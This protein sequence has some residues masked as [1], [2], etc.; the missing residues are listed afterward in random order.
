MPARFLTSLGGVDLDKSRNYLSYHMETYRGIYWKTK[1]RMASHFLFTLSFWCRLGFTASLFCILAG[2]KDGVSRGIDVDPEAKVAE[3]PVPVVSPIASGIPTAAD[4]VAQVVVRSPMIDAKKAEYK[5]CLYS[6]ELAILSPLSGEKVARHLL[7]FFPGFLDREMQPE[8]H[9]KLGEVLRVR[10]QHYD[11]MP[12]VVRDLARID[13]VDDFELSRWFAVA[14]VKLKVP[15]TAFAEPPRGAFLEE[16]SVAESHKPVVWPRSPAAAEIRRR[17][18]EEDQ[19]RITTALARNGGT[20]QKWAER[21][22]PFHAE[23]RAKIE[24]PPAGQ[25]REGNFYLE[26]LEEKAYAELCEKG[27]QGKPGPLAMLIHLNTQLRQRGID[28]I[29]APVPRKEV[30]HAEQFSSLAPADGMYVANRQRFLKQLLDA[31]V[32]VIDFVPAY[33]R[34]RDQHEWFFYDASDF[35]PADGGIQVQ[36]REITARLARYQFRQMPG[37]V[38]LISR[39]RPSEFVVPF[40]GSGMKKG[41]RYPAT[42][43]DFVKGGHFEGSHGTLPSPI[44][45]MGDSVT[46]FPNNHADEQNLRAHLTHL[47]GVKL[48]HLT[49]LGGSSQAGRLLAREGGD[50]LADRWVVVFAFAPTRLFGSRSSISGGKEGWDLVDLPPLKFD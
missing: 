36:A 33:Q 5:D 3:L 18:I 38:P 4:V 47:C 35:H 24:A 22:A 12:Q 13:E 49:S 50:F 34:A 40:D 26:E 30:V 9:F 17:Q 10:L 29:V 37:Y 48:E 16:A 20:W 2:C 42:A 41:T 44:V 27:E 11:E 31:D 15:S 25:A 43:V 19:K 28:L 14:S 1:S 23:L 8:S 21:L 45:L 7:A 32:E 39:T 6:A 46:V